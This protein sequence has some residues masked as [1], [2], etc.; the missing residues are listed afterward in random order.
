MY[1]CKDCGNTIRFVVD[2]MDRRFGTV[3][4]EWLE[5]DG[6]WEA[7][8]ATIIEEDGD[9]HMEPAP[10]ACAVCQSPRIEKT[11]KIDEEDGPDR[12]ARGMGLL[13]P[14]EKPRAFGEQQGG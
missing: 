3:E 5:D 14:K 1:R 6:E 4:A 13:F 2:F 7:D 9:V 10:S 8:R 11:Q 12:G